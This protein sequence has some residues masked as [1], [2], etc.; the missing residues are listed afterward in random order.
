[1]AGDL[2]AFM[3][4]VRGYGLVN[5][6][7]VAC[8]TGLSMSPLRGCHSRDR[9]LRRRKK[10]VVLCLSTFVLAALLRAD[11][12]APPKADGPKTDAPA[13][14]AVDNKSDGD[15]KP[16]AEKRLD[17]RA[18]IRKLQAR[19]DVRADKTPLKQIVAQLSKQHDVVI[20]LDEAALKKAGVEPDEPLTA[21]I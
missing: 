7:P 15:K 5:V 18:M 16:A 20:Q 9:M 21:T 13:K 3:P 12:A 8:A 14:A 1:M 19:T 2:D 4:P 17:A 10:I 6:Q 11:D